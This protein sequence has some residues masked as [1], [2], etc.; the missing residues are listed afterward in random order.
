MA[1]AAYDRAYLQAAAAELEAYL[2]SPELYHTLTVTAPPKEPPF[3]S[4]TPGNLLLAYTRLRAR[5][6]LEA[7]RLWQPIAA[8]RNQW[9]AHWRSKARRE[10]HA[11][12]ERWHEYLRSL[13]LDPSQTDYYP[14]E[15]RQRVIIH[16]LA[17][18]LGGLS[19]EEQRFLER[20]DRA[21]QAIF[22]PGLWI[23]EADLQPAFSRD[24]FWYL[25][26]KPES[27]LA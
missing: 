15:V 5:E 4:L 22:R 14:Y 12:L 20:T 17:E 8:L 19:E 1:T 6:A 18:D 7:D 2:L 11:R 23:W 27:D 9:E 10:M 21:L 25:Y 26:G 24:L 13:Q 16:L 3:P